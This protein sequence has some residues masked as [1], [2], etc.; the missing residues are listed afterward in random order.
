MLP[1]WTVAGFAVYAA[2]LAGRLYRHNF[3]VTIFTSLVSGINRFAARNLSERVA[4]I[5]SVL[6]ETAWNKIRA[7]DD[8]EQNA[9]DEYG[10]Q[11]NK[12]LRIFEFCHPNSLV[13]I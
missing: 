7:Q 9:S 2:V 6:A 8:K 3:A 5:V 10:R 1:K 4:A 12:V 11:S 13:Q